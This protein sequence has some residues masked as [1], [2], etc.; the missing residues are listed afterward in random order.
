MVRL[1]LIIKIN[2]MKGCLIAIAIYFS[3]DIL[4]YKL[5]KYN[6]TELKTGIG[7]KVVWSNRDRAFCLGLSSFSWISV[8]AISCVI[9]LD[10]L[11]DDK[12]AKW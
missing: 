11:D 12:P 9:A 1:F 7:A 4:S 8:G 10:H 6:R 2:Y 3:G 5:M